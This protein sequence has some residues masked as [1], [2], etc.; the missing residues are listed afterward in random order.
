MSEVFVIQEERESSEK[1]NVIDAFRDWKSA[2]S[3]LNSLIEANDLFNSDSIINLQNG[4][5]ESDPLYNEEEY[6]N[7]RIIKFDV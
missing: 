3:R 2:I 4:I 6:C 7:Y 1:C 5:A